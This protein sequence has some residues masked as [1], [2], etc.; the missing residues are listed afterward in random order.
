MKVRNPICAKLRSN[1]PCRIGYTEGNSACSISLS[2]WQRLA[3]HRTEKAAFALPG[4]TAIAWVDT[5]L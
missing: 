4:L 2:K 1:P 5:I 3:A